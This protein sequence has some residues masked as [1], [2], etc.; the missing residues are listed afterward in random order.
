MAALN[1]QRKNAAKRKQ[2]FPFMR[3]LSLL[4]T[5]LINGILGAVVAAFVADWVATYRRVSN[6]EGGRLYLV[7]LA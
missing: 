6:F 4:A 7:A 1:R 3:W 5:G 2:K